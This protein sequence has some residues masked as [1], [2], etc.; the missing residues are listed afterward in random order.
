MV[1]APST[2]NVHT[3]STPI[4]SQTPS[5]SVQRV[6]ANTGER[7]HVVR[8][9][10]SVHARTASPKN[11]ELMLDV[12][13]VVFANA[14]D[15]RT[16][17]RGRVAPVQH[18]CILAVRPGFPN[19][20]SIL[21]ALVCVW[22][23]LDAIAFERETADIVPAAVSYLH[24]VRAASTL[25]IVLPHHTVSALAPAAPSWNTA[26]W[27]ALVARCRSSIHWWFPFLEDAVR[28]PEG[29]GLG[30]LWLREWSALQP[31]TRR[32]EDWGALASAVRRGA[33]E[34]VETRV[35]FER[36]HKEITL[37]RARGA[38]V[39]A[40]TASMLYRLCRSTGMVH[41][42]A[43][44][45]LHANGEALEETRTLEEYGVD[46]ETTLVFGS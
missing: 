20:H 38:C 23:A 42:E 30:G 36:A 44:D 12:E 15:V 32:V 16:H 35:C 24:N 14:A 46:D 29:P 2:K 43:E 7:S 22:P 25:R 17:R 18:A 28:C 37:W 8:S 26:M 5:P 41:V 45:G 19:T 39:Q 21:H 4:V 34:L 10:F 3:A 33:I 31:G 27:N 11:M 6:N 9:I 13:R 1:R 40:I